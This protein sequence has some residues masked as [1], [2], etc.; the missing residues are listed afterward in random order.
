[1]I[2][3][4]AW[5]A[6]HWNMGVIS[7]KPAA[8]KIY[9]IIDDTCISDSN[10]KSTFMKVDPLHFWFGKFPSEMTMEV[11]SKFRCYYGGKP[12]LAQIM[13]L[14][15]G[16]PDVLIYRR[17]VHVLYC[18]MRRMMIRMPEPSSVEAKLFAS[19]YQPK[20]D[21][22]I[23]EFGGTIRYGYSVF[24][25]HLTFFQQSR[26]NKVD[27]ETDL[28]NLD[29]ELMTKVEL[30]IIDNPNDWP[31]PRAISMPSEGHKYATGPL[32]FALEF[33]CKK[34]LDGFASGLS[35]QDKEQFLNLAETRDLTVRVADDCKGWDLGVKIENDAFTYFVYKLIDYFII[36]ECDVDNILKHWTTRWHK[37]TAKLREGDS[38]N[39]IGYIVLLD[40]MFSG[41]MITLLKNTF[42][43]IFMK[44]YVV[45]TKLGVSNYMLMCSGDDSEVFLPTGTSRDLA[46]D[47]F[48]TI[49]TLNGSD[50]G[51]GLWFKFL[52][53]S[54][55]EGFNF[56]QTEAFRCDNCGW[57]LIRIMKNV[58]IKMMYSKKFLQLSSRAR[59]VYMTA[60]YD[61]GILW[62]KGLPIFHEH[63][64]H[65][66]YENRDYDLIMQGSKKE[67][68]FVEEDLAYL[69]GNEP[70]V[71][72][73]LKE[74]DRDY[75]Y[76]NRGRISSKLPCCVSAYVSMLNVRY[77][78]TDSDISQIQK[79]I[80][81]PINDE[82]DSDLLVDALRFRENYQFE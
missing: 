7:F 29:I 5:L 54:G 51:L 80:A 10:Y 3:Q 62:C 68:L 42:N 48:L 53:V 40:E 60:L 16:L 35:F 67:T 17:C 50:G 75:Y 64:Q 25:N 23:A 9:N 26:I 76:A 41:T 24:Y 44:K 63:Y 36:H 1:M 11:F 70:P 73:M 8:C 61:S 37:V 39:K 57:K 14:Y 74:I 46:R 47:A 82:I 22:L 43:N 56:C 18:S 28:C 20:I 38:F 58:L 65:F 69:V 79:D 27:V 15:L 78:L 4:Q 31:K 81:N 45:E 52:I 59:E 71:F 66:N 21:N 2:M 32:A 33:F 77:G 72:A 12:G 30:Q 6:K 55:L 13:P 19:F 49:G 34:H